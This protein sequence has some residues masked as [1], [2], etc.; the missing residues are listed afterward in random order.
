VNAN[1][2]DGRTGSSRSSTT[3]AC[4]GTQLFAG[5]PCTYTSLAGSA[6]LQT[7]LSYAGQ[8]MYPMLRTGSATSTAGAGRFVLTTPGASYGCQTLASSGCASALSSY[9][10]G[11]IRFGAF[12]TGSW[13]EGPTY[14][15]EIANYSDSALAQRGVLE[16]ATAPTMTRS[17]S[18]RFWNGSSY[19]TVALT[20]TSSGIIAQSGTVTWSPGAGIT[21]TASAAVS[22]TPVSSQI[23]GENPVVNCKSDACAVRATAGSV[24]VNLHYQV[25]T[26]TASWNISQSTVIA[27]SAASASFESRS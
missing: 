19:A 14:L 15:V 4:N 27:G 11:S 16:M 8:T 3:Q 1:A 13:I 6:G 22:S 10:E 20:P 9:A 24:T 5:A 21:V 17:A 26:P 23:L 7:A 25:V 18:V 12:S 2:D